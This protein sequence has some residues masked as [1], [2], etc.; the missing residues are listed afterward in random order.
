M[1]KISYPDWWED[2][3]ARFPDEYEEDKEPQEIYINE[4][5]EE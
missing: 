5:I 3:Y 1:Y 4:E 2:P